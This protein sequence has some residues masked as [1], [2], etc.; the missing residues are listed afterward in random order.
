MKI[1]FAL[2]VFASAAM[3]EEKAVLGGGCFW[4]VEAVYR[5]RP[6]IKSV[7]SGYAGGDVRNPEHPY[8]RA[9]IAPKL[10]KLNKLNK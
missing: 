4:C 7:V 6:G 1:L 9:V 5:S 2:L 3:C 10:E 8:N